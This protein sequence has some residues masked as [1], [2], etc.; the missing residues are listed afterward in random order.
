MKLENKI[1]NKELDNGKNP[2]D[3]A[4]QSMA[5]EEIDELK[6][7]MP[8]KITIERD[9]EDKENLMINSIEDKN[10]LELSES[11]I[12]IHIQ[13]LGIDNQYWL[14]SGAFNF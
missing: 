3:A 10:G 2:S 6:K 8:F 1:R 12:E 7:R 13:S 11:C 5:N 14:D 4:V 9:P